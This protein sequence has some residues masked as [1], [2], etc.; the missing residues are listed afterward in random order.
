MASASL[1]NGFHQEHDH[2]RSA[3]ISLGS[4]AALLVGILGA[5]VTLLADLELCCRGIVLLF[6]G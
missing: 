6:L 5:G 1:G 4:A 2:V 3:S